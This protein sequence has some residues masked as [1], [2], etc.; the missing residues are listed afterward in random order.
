[1]LNGFVT[2]TPVSRLTV[3]G[4]D[5]IKNLHCIQLG[6]VD[7]ESSNFS[8][9]NISLAVYRGSRLACIGPNWS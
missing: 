6:E 7:F 5:I 3:W 1:M 8:L 9:S 4:W 2:P